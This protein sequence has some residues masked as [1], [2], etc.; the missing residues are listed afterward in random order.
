MSVALMPNET[1]SI[2]RLSGDL[3]LTEIDNLLRVLTDLLYENQKQVILNMRQVTHVSLGGISRLAER[4]HKLKSLNGEIKLTGL[5]P[6][7]A[8]LFKLV[9]AYSQFDV[10]SDEEQAVARFES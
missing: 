10:V 4:N 6:Y 5:I 8:N 1:V 2:I 7:V 9:G 3:S